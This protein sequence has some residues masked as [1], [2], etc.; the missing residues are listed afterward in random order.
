MYQSQSVQQTG[1]DGRKISEKKQAYRDTK[2]GIEKASLQRMLD[3]KGHKFVRSQIRGSGEE[4]EHNI[5][6]GMNEGT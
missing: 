5:F 6:K 3:D 1:K 2:S 4:Y